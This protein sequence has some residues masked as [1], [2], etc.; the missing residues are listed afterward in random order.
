VIRRAR[1]IP[2][3]RANQRGFVL[4]TV[5]IILALL[6]LLGV[7]Q[8]YRSITV[9]QES[10][11]SVKSLQAAYYAETAISYIRWGWANDVDFDDGNSGAAGNQLLGDREEWLT[12]ITNPTSVIAYW[13][14]GADNSTA[15]DRAVFWDN[16]NCLPASSA[17]SYCKPTLSTITT[18]L[19]SRLN[20][21][22]KLEINQTT[23]VITPS[24]EN[25]GAV[26]TNGAVI[27][28]T[29]GDENR[30]YHVDNSQCTP[31]ATTFGCFNDGSQDVQYHVVAYGLG[32]VDGTPLHLMRAVIR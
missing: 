17:A 10:A 3:Q 21:Y 16:S 2:A 5:L 32:F 13:D 30:D 12:A 23:G 11:A 18:D 25:T 29:A 26:P 20:G 27:W 22:I 7:A 19:N 24:L 9:Q 4:L 31:P 28:V 15:T 1:Q 6:S 8:L 14:N